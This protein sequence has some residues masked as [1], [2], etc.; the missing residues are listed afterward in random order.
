V[1][2][3]VTNLTIEPILISL[4]SIGLQVLMK[5]APQLGLLIFLA[6]GA[7]KV[8]SAVPFVG[9]AMFMLST[10]ANIATIGETLIECL[11]CPAIDQT[12]VSLMMA[13]SV[14][15]SHDPNDFQFPATAHSYIVKAFYDGG[16][17]PVI[18]AGTVQPGTVGPIEVK[19]KTTA[20][21]GSQQD[22]ASGGRVQAQ[23]F[24]YSASGCL[25]GQG[26]S[27]TLFNLPA[28]KATDLVIPITIQEMLVPLDAHTSYIHQSKLS[29]SNGARRWDSSAPPPLLTHANLCQG[30]DGAVCALHGLTVH[31]A[32]GMAGY[33][34]NAGG[35]NV[36]LCTGGTAA[37]LN[38]VQNVFLGDRPDSGLKFSSCGE[39][40]PIG[41]VYS[42]KG[43]KTG[44][45]NF[46]LQ[47]GT[48]EVYHL[49]SVDLG[50][51]NFDMRQTLSWG[52]FST[53]L[54]SLCVMNNG[55]VA[56][57]NRST[58]K[59]EVLRLPA[60]PSSTS[61]ELVSVPFAALAGGTGSRVGLLDTPV[62]VCSH[63][64]ALLV[65]EQGNQRVQA[66][67]PDGN[68]VELFTDANGVATSLLAL[69]EEAGITYLD[70]A[71]EGA[72]YVYVLSYADSGSSAANYR[73]DV[74][75]PTG[76][77]LSRTARVA[78]G[79][80]A[81]DLYRNVYTLNYE[82]MAN[83]PRVE[84]SLSQWA[85]V[86]TTPSASTTSNRRSGTKKFAAQYGVPTIRSA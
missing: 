31:T 22:V 59:M 58:N 73:L 24:F 64:G 69:Q 28:D 11:S 17:T 85:A 45:Q 2:S 47:Q 26:T 13:S 33:G 82:T 14:Q 23:V 12:R 61:N 20:A 49:R 53:P 5:C 37:S 9:M 16:T 40:Q 80:I 41:I 75:T 74:Y 35:Q 65:L 46:F 38:T 54:D 67:D 76:Q 30:N 27:E 25:V 57:V 36:S 43:P 1:Q 84:P 39:S 32:S 60:A 42:P 3:T 86:S 44:G 34:F 8:A 70:V 6:A 79:N 56:G 18:V 66:F 21:D 55:Y 78:A 52:R 48:D 72:G 10:V 4:G 68:A 77:F 71:V 62:A 51:G 81:V 7:S 19:L 83:S 50:G 63:D 29:Y 15:I